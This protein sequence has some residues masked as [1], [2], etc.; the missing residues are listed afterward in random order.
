MA[1]AGQGFVDAA[2]PDLVPVLAVLF[3]ASLLD[4]VFQDGDQDIQKRISVVLFPLLCLPLLLLEQ[5][6]NR[7]DHNCVGHTSTLG[8]R[9]EGVLPPFIL[10]LFGTRMGFLLGNHS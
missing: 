1:G 5:V 2:L 6:L 9:V 7:D 8:G 4:V 3:L 10:I